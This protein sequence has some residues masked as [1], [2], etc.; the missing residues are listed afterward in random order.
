MK[1]VTSLG[2][3]HSTLKQSTQIKAGSS[4]SLIR[5]SNGDDGTDG[6][7]RSNGN[8]NDGRGKGDRR[9]KIRELVDEVNY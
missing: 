5:N 7:L 8:N 2:E 1:L 4:S 6:L 9:A 3:I